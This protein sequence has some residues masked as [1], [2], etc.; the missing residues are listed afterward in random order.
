MLEWLNEPLIKA[1]LHVNLTKR[2]EN[3]N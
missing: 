2:F 1:E 3:C